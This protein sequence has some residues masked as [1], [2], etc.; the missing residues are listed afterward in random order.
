M[1]G[2]KMNDPCGP[3]IYYIPSWSCWLAGL[4]IP[5]LNKFP[6]LTENVNF[7]SLN[8]AAPIYCLFGSMLHTTSVWSLD[9]WLFHLHCL[10]SNVRWTDALALLICL[11]WVCMRRQSAICSLDVTVEIRVK[12]VKETDYPG[13]SSSLLPW[14]E[15]M[16]CSPPFLWLKKQEL[17]K[18]EK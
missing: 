6:S 16:F 7:S 8:H 1:F 13:K 12:C 17:L 11:F 14:S 10:P 2:I 15:T 9:I 3:V 5:P 4:T 18:E